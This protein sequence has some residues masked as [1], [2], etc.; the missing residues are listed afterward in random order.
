MGRSADNHLDR[1]GKSVGPFYQYDKAPGGKTAVVYVLGMDDAE[2]AEFSKNSGRIY[3]RFEKVIW[4]VTCGD[5]SPLLRREF[6]VEV[7]PH[8]QHAMSGG[9]VWK[10][11][12]ER[13]RDILRMKWQPDWSLSFG[14]RFDEYTDMFDTREIGEGNLN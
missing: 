1:N 4:V 2:V 9:R 5:I 11:F 10:P 3:R 8:P 12:L 6:L 13:R 7:L 14:W